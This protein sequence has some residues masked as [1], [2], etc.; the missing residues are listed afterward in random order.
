LPELVEQ[1][2]LN[3]LGSLEPFAPELAICGTIIV[4]LLVRL[5]DFLR[6]LDACFIALAGTLIA[7]LLA[8]LTDL[9]DDRIEIFT[10]MLVYDGFARFVRTFLL[11][12]G[13]LFIIFTYLSGVPQRED[14]TDFYTLFLG[15]TLGMCLMATANHMLT[16]FLA[17]EMASIPSY[18][19][20]GSLRQRRSS[21]A[22]LKYAVYGAGAAGIM[23]YG[24]SLV[25]G[26]THSA[27]LPT[28]AA[29]LAEM[30][31]DKQ[32]HSGEA[33]ALALGGLMI[34][35]G[36]A[37]KL[38][39]VPFHFWCPDVFEGAAAEI[40]AFLSVASKAAALALLVRVA[41]GLGLVPSSESVVK[42]S[43]SGTIASA[44]DD[45][46][47]TSG[48]MNVADEAET[49]IAITIEERETPSTALSS[50]ESTRPLRPSAISRRS[51]FPSSPRSPARSATSRPMAKRTSS[52]CSP[53]RRSPTPV[54]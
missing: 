38:S 14:R 51:S 5:F 16:V 53:I 48:L 12:F 50:A 19:L 25:S 34:M 44:T 4:L 28:M 52:A 2:K 40:G 27:H 8:A 43:A 24:I 9:P 41:L 18:V 42:T 30:F 11:G 47:A 29:Q 22:A 54:T 17:V 37:F 10:G 33:M 1:L 20:A 7:L 3:T 31:H 23:V 45:A 32:I 15:G 13:V 35:V 26:I 36:L 6:W 46:I 21:E 49:P 39:A